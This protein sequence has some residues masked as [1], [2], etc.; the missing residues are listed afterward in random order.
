[1]LSGDDKKNL[2]TVVGKLASYDYNDPKQTAYLD[3]ISFENYLKGMRSFA[4]WRKGTP[5][6]SLR[7]SCS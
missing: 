1:L 2:T 5:T 3:G 7:A 4:S 6:S